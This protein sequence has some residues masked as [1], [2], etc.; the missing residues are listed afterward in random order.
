[1]DLKDEVNLNDE[2]NLKEEVILKEEAILKEPVV[3][4]VQEGEGEMKGK[5]EG[6]VDHHEEES[7]DGK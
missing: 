3:S 4:K 2:V 6:K 5:E 7:F 1:M